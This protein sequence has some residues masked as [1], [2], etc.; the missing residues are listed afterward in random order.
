M[1]QLKIIFLYYYIIILTPLKMNNEVERGKTLCDW[2]TN[3]NTFKT[4]THNL[5]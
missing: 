2:N 3:F 4:N 5:E 1:L